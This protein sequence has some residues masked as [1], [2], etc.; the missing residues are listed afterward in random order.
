MREWIWHFFKI[1]KSYSSFQ[2]KDNKEIS[3]IADTYTFCCF[4]TNW[5]LIDAKY[6]IVK[7]RVVLAWRPDIILFQ[8]KRVST[9]SDEI[10]CFRTWVSGYVSKVLSLKSRHLFLASVVFNLNGTLDP[11]GFNSRVTLF[12]LHDDLHRLAVLD[13]N[14]T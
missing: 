5:C 1:I 9:R 3:L 2:I 14:V 12:V 7:T 8:R 10:A 13:T 6:V 11:K 4:L